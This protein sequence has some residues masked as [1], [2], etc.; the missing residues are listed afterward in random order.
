M[1]NR[2]TAE[3]WSIFGGQWG[4]TSLST[5]LSGLRD[6]EILEEP[7][8]FVQT[9]FGLFEKDTLEPFAKS[10]KEELGRGIP[11]REYKC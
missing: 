5:V 2:S 1:Q 7:L 6:I 8:S 4:K 11:W 9:L 3:G 10:A